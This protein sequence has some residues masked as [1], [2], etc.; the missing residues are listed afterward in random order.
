MAKYV[1]TSRYNGK[2]ISMSCESKG[3][4][5]LCVRA[6][7][8]KTS[9]QFSNAE[10]TYIM[11]QEIKLTD[12]AFQAYDKLRYGDTDRQGHINNAVFTTLLETGRV[13]FFRSR[14]SFSISNAKFAGRERFRSE[15]AWRQLDAAR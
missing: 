10:A 4:H 12:Y 15:R 1:H 8:K 5:W 13:E 3:G 9:S 7:E 2:R 11:D 6:C 14:G